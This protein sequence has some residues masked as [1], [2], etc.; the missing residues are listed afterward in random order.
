MRSS[1][2]AQLM[3]TNPAPPPVKEDL[4]CRAINLC[5]RLDEVNSRICDIRARLF[6]GEAV[7][8]A[9][10]DCVTNIEE[11]LVRAHTLVSRIMDAMEGIT[12]NL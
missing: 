2:S 12:A 1:N 7:A 9:P 10:T 8:D 5:T 6:G 3:Q 11:S 4:R